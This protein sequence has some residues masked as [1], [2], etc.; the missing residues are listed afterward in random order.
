MILI[1]QR[2]LVHYRAP[3]LK[4]LN[5]EIGSIV[6][7]GKKG[8]PISRHLV[9]SA[10]FPH[11]ELWEW[12]LFP[13]SNEV[14]VQGVIGPLFKLKPTVVVI[15]PG[16]SILSNWII[17]VLKYFLRY[18]L[19]LWGHG[20]NRKIGFDPKVCFSDKLR[21][22]WMDRAD[23]VIVYSQKTKE[24][25]LRYMHNQDKIFIVQNTLDTKRLT[26]IRDALDSEGKAAVKGKLG[27]KE[28]YNII[29][30][31][32]ILKEKEPDRLINVF[33]LLCRRLDSIALHFVGDG[34][35]LDELKRQAEGMKVVFWGRITDD[36]TA[37]RLLYASDMMVIPGYLGLSVV[38]TLCFD[39][40]IM[41]QRKGEQGPF[42]SPE[43]E[44][45]IDGK[46]GF[47]VEYGDDE[48][49]ASR[50]LDYFNDEPQQE[51][52][53]AE[54]RRMVESKCTIE[55]MIG[56]FK[57]AVHYVGPRKEGTGHK[58]DIEVGV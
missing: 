29:F 19:I 16:L 45:V 13:K 20:F 53:K 46:T 2:C 11:Y 52:M 31:G 22:W 30:T 6:C 33:K 28:K 40:P 8:P 7:F 4:L 1:F 37:G 10:D 55:Q 49:M 51:F 24:M 34:P 27:W 54:M 42:H 17:L 32:R 43:V 26:E 41:S 39:T 18:K 47:L 36:Y 9:T 56:G 21:L 15:D 38:H 12:H 3:I 23:A 48:A 57:S 14:V 58:K 25:F 5:K 44:Y 35:F 50:I